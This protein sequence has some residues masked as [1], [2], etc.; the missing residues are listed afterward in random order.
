MD[1]E[2]LE[3]RSDMSLDGGF[4][5]IELVG[6]LLVGLALADQGQH[7]VLLRCQLAQAG[8]DFKLAVMRGGEG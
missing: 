6:D 5:D 1:G 3:D 8:K 7:L 4:H 2:L